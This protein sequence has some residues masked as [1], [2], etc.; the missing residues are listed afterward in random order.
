LIDDDFRKS[1]EAHKAFLKILRAN[2]N[3]HWA[4]RGMNITG[5]L[6]RFI[7]EFRKVVG[8]GQFNRYHAYTVDE[9]TLRAIGEARNFWH[10]DREMRLPLA[11]DVCLKIKRPE[12]LYLALLFHDIAKG[13]DGDHSENGAVIARGFCQRIGLNRDATD[14]IE[15]LVRQH[16]LMAVKSQRFDLSDPEVIREF[17]QR[18]GDLE[19]LKFLLLLTVADIAAVGPNVWNDWKGTLLSEIYH[20]TAQCLL[21]EQAGGEAGEQRYRTRL[22]TVLE[23]AEGD[24]QSIQT[25][26]GLL[27]KPCV[28]H[29][30]PRQ[31]RKI[32]ELLV[33][34][35]DDAV[36]LWVD[37]ERA[38]TLAFVVA[39]GRVGLFAAL[40]ATLTSGN[41]SIVAAQAYK[42]ADEPRVLDVF[43]LQTSDG[44]PFDI[45]ADLER[46]ESRINRLLLQDDIE[47]MKV[48][49]TFKVNVLM[50]RVPVRVREL[51]KASYHE[52]AIEVSAANQPRLLAR[53]AEVISTEGYALHGASVSTFGERAV[54]V[55]FITGKQ[56]E[57]LSTEQI[58]ALCDMLA[59]E[60]T[61]P[62][63]Q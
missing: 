23:T 43:H 58:T 2:R 19:R 33:G 1:P 24:R 51:P 42:L 35:P 38:E 7:P 9:H 13:L 46:M 47:T 52:T 11:H 10:R 56:S 20:A 61:L 36:H 40:A 31:L 63:E 28:M 32:T 39:R 8:L 50:R 57:Q 3:V 44:A 59:D 41:A 53:L 4:L 26:L 25:A 12:L 55:F 34:H 48:D 15:W 30:P 60:A 14:L 29:F 17:A 37:R 22:Q 45:A 21:G 18:V 5:V 62:P 54:D 16:L 6:G 27:S 49:K